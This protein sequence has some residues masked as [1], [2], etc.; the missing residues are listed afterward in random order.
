MLWYYESD[1]GARETGYA[2]SF[3][4]AFG[5]AVACLELCAVACDAAP[6]RLFRSLVPDEF[7]RTALDFSVCKQ[8]I[9]CKNANATRCGVAYA[10]AARILVS[11]EA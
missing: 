6:N 7:N 2:R 10:T 8:T 5:S 3:G 9:K 11:F 4:L 1:E